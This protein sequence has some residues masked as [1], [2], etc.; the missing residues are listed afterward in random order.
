MKSLKILSTTILL[1]AS[2]IGCSGDATST[3]D[4][5]PTTV[6][7]PETTTEQD[8]TP[9]AKVV[10]DM[11]GN[12]VEL[13]DNIARVAV[14]YPSTTDMMVTLGLTEKIAGTYRTTLDNPWV[15]KIVPESVDW[16][17]FEYSVSVETIAEQN[18]DLVFIP[19]KSSAETFTNAGICTV[20][21]R[22]YTEDDAFDTEFFECARILGEIF[23]VED[24]ALA[25]EQS[26]KDLT[27]EIQTTIAESS[28][29]DREV[30][31]YYVNG[32]KSKGLWYS[33]GGNSTI[34]TTLEIFGQRLATDVY[35]VETVHGASTEEMISLDPDVII[36][37]GVYQKDLFDE[38][39]ADPI[40][41]QLSCVLEDKVY[42]I[43]VGFIG[44]ENISAETTV[45]LKYFA[46]IFYPELFDYNIEE[47]LYNCFNTYFGYELSDEE[48]K[49]MLEGLSYT[50]DSLI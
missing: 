32:E 24:K 39:Y 35:L 33:D 8:I 9:Q 6:E 45:M 42:N 5:A 19:D 15:E 40:W 29:E 36:I 21:I 34:Q 12:T 37:G 26:V 11:A 50:G 41:N 31:V 16:F 22:Q 38:L 48:I 28:L 49:Y 7:I 43:P 1:I 17:S 4:I 46:N 44:I 25:W 30:S 10:V 2:L 3:Q 14:I 18:I 23:D 27:E 20:V 47:E 13:P